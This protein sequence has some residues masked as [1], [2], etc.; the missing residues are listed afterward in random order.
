M[1]ITTIPIE[2]PFIVL[3]DV[4]E[5]HP[6]P[7]T[8]LYTDADHDYREIAVR[9]RW[10]SL[11]TSNGDYSIEGHHPNTLKNANPNS[12]G[13]SVERKS[14]E[15]CIGTILG[16]ADRRP[17]FER[18]LHSLQCLIDLGG[19]AVVIVEGSMGTV[20]D[21]VTEHGKKSREDNVKSLFR[22]WISFL[23]DYRVPWMFC[24]DR[25]LAEIACYRWLE[26]FHRKV[27]RTRSA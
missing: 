19:S 1:S 15:D 14:I 20:L 21:A 4:Q 17:R 23:Q 2:S 18:E 22:S 25:R 26:R 27:C 9:H 7:F 5:K 16:F 24:D 13:V 12:P 8:G 6:F 11:G 3:I 10:E